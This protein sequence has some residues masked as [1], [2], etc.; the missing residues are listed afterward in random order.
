MQGQLTRWMAATALV[1][2]A[3]SGEDDPPPVDAPCGEPRIVVTD[4]ATLAA[5]LD[6]ATAG[7]CIVLR[8]GTYQGPVVVDIDGVT[9]AAAT[10]ETVVVRG[11]EG[12]TAIRVT[13]D[14]VTVI[15]VDTEGGDYGVTMV[16]RRGKFDAMAM[17]AALEA[18]VGIR[19]EDQ[20]CLDVAQRTELLD[21]VLSDSEVGI[22]IS[23]ANVLVD[24][25]TIRNISS[26]QLSGGGGIY[27]VDGAHVLVRNTTLEGNE[28]GLVGDGAMTRVAIEGCTV[29]DNNDGGVWAQGM[30]A[31]TGAALT[32]TGGTVFERNGRVGIGTIGASGVALDGVTIRDTVLKPFLDNAMRQVMVGDGIGLFDGTANTTLRS[33]T[34]LDNGRAHMLVDDAGAGITLDTSVNVSGGMHDVVVQRSPNNT[35]NVPMNLLTNLPNPLFVKD[36]RITVPVMP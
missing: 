7:T 23:G 25:A 10:G 2:G 14:G 1:L 32:V 18:A 35:V 5:A 21:L 9:L 31:A 33:V 28:Y 3:C 19:C 15:D 8:E 6:E 17:K 34:L 13:A 22:L 24:G 27:A 29:A 20:D 30:T 16:G 11:A 36:D 4:D 26:Q 12:G